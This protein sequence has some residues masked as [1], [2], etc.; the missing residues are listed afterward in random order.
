MRVIAKNTTTDSEGTL[1]AAP[2]APPDGW[3]ILVLDTHIGRIV[4]QED[5]SGAIK[6]THSARGGFGGGGP[7][8]V[9]PCAPGVFVLEILPR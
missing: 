3:D 4:L 6:V 7:L 1:P 5:P 2:N 8:A 9:L